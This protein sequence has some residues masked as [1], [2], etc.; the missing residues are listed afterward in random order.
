MAFDIKHFINKKKV[1]Q[2]LNGSLYP[3]TVCSQVSSYEEPPFHIVNFFS[4]NNALYPNKSRF[5]YTCILKRQD[6]EI[7]NIYINA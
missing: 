1:S 5:E 3:Q 7:R 6:I 2:P 4:L